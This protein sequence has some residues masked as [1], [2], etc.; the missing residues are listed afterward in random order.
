MAASGGM[1]HALTQHVGGFSG[2]VQCWA[3]SLGPDGHIR[4][5]KT[6]SL[7]DEPC[8]E[9]QYDLDELQEF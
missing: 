1:L 8:A 2:T 6:Q 3:G 9:D 5:K 7:E 4:R